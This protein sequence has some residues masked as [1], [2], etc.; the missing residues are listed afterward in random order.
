[1]TAVKWKSTTINWTICNLTV[2]KQFDLLSSTLKNAEKK[3]EI[4]SMLKKY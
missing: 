3:L 4:W 2:L 1:M